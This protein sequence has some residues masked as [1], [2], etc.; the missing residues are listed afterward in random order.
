MASASAIVGLAHAPPARAPARGGVAVAAGTASTPR[1]Q[2]TAKAFNSIGD[3][4]QNERVCELREHVRALATGKPVLL[5]VNAWDA[6]SEGELALLRRLCGQHSVASALDACPVPTI[7]RDKLRSLWKAARGNTP[8]RAMILA[9]A[10]WHSEGSDAKAG[11]LLAATRSARRTAAHTLDQRPGKEFKPV[12]PTSILRC[13]LRGGM[14]PV[15]RQVAALSWLEN[16][17]TRPSNRDTRVQV[18]I[19]R[20]GAPRVTAVVRPRT[21]VS[22]PLFILFLC[23][24]SAP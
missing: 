22:T 15:E 21:W 19:G 12:A 7:L 6:L 1:K 10:R 2:R 9:V 13:R 14:T 20:K 18:L 24:Y 11:A 8:W 23:V 4:P 17:H 3:R 5:R 16:N